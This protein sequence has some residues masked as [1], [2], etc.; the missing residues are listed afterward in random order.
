MA[1]LDTLVWQAEQLGDALT[2]LARESGLVARN[3]TMPAAGR[4]P[5]TAKPDDD[6]ARRRWVEQ[7]AQQ[8]GIEAEPMDTPYAE[9][10]LLISHAAP[11]LI[12]LPP[13]MDDA[14]P[15][16][17]ALL[18]NDRRRV[19]LLT[20][21][22][23]QRTIAT[24]V[25]RDA[26][27]AAVEAPF[28]PTV[29]HVLNRAKVEGSRRR[30][31]QQAMLAHQLGKARVAQGWLLRR[32]PRAVDW[33]HL[34]TVRAPALVAILLA[35][36]LLQQG[37]LL[38]TWSVI[39]GGA[40]QGH[41]ESAKLSAW[42]LLMLM[43]VPL[44][45]LLSALSAR[46]SIGIG[47]VFKNVL[48]YGILQLRPEEIRHQG[49]GQFLGRVM[50]AGVVESGALANTLAVAFSV[51]QL[52]SALGVLAAGVGSWISVGLLGLV[53]LVIIAL[54]WQVWQNNDQWVD[55][56]RNMT[57]HL[58]EQMVG[59][60]TRLAQLAPEAWHIDEDADLAQYLDTSEQAARTGNWFAAL[61]R[62]WMILG[63]SSLL[64]MLVLQK[65]TPQAIAISLGGIMLAEQ[66]L[67][68]IVANIRSMIGFTKSWR[69]V[70]PLFDAGKR[71]TEAGLMIPQFGDGAATEPGQA[72]ELLTLR[73][74]SYRYRE[75]GRAVLKDVTMQI[76][77]G[78]RWL[79]EGPS[80]GG[81]STLAAVLAGLRVP[82]SGL[83]LLHGYDRASVGLDAWRRR[84][85]VAPQFHENHVFTESFAFNLLMG[86]NWPASESDIAE[87][88]A[89]CHELGLGDLISRMPGGLMQIVGESG[90]QLSHGEQSRLFI[91]R[92][93]LQHAD[94]IILDESFA[95]LDPENLAR[96]MSCV[97]RHAPTVLVIA[98][99]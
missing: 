47:S 63:L 64:P 49:I 9:V 41:F 92:A 70:K 31:A 36:V 60:R 28:L 39:G 33:H 27:C 87:A 44:Q 59:Y 17:I 83:L 26:L 91:A 67:N 13:A 8:I 50:D 51:I 18:R 65:A 97:L 1:V 32:P 40:L 78:D 15:R 90:W 82:E 48:L 2:M 85:V 71:K 37:L 22:Q 42:A 73:E 14:A 61:P 95:A 6:A 77:T 52:I 7:L 76:R 19:T 98:H 79:V 93:L 21:E 86:R 3:A 62:V 45:M 5:Y 72:Q 58:V 55:A 38:L 34:N 74:V 96:A 46:L 84:V 16:Y 80:G 94:L 23:T 66:A 30:G 89:L 24:D 53:I 35:T 88:T 57:N 68:T 69:Q 54:A 4:H 43:G 99:P 75:R 20:P 10:E 29:E 56:Y 25:L 12:I 81:K 11:A